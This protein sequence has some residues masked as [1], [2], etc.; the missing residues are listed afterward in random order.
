MLEIGIFMKLY[1][2]KKIET[3]QETR[4]HGYHKD[5]IRCGKGFD[6]DNEIGEKSPTVQNHCHLT[7]EVQRVAHTKGN[8]NTRKNCA[9]IVPIAC[10]NSS[11]Y[12]Q[13]HHFQ[14]LIDIATGKTYETKGDDI[15]KSSENKIPVKIGYLNFLDSYTFLN[16]S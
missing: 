5:K 9:S 8:L 4:D 11:G 1:S 7:V 14:K 15:A 12:D 13:H 2:E 3:K 6:T 10:L 16:A